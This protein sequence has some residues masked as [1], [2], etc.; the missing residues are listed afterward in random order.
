MKNTPLNVIV[1]TSDEMRADCLGFMGNPDV[2]TPCLYAFARKGVVFENHFTVHGKCVPSRVAMMTGRYCHTDGFRTITQHLPKGDPNLMTF[3]RRRGYETAVFGHNHVWDD[4][5]CGEEKEKVRSG[6]AADYHSFVKPFHDMAFTAYAVP[7]SSKPVECMIPGD[8]TPHSGRI[9]GAIKGFNDYNRARQAVHY[10]KNVRDRSKPFYLHVNMG[11]PHPAYRVEEPFFSMYDRAKIKTW[12]H[13]VP[14]NAPL[15]FRVMRE[16]RTG[17]NIS[18]RELREVQAVY[19]GMISRGDR[20]LGIV[21]ECIERDGLLE[22]SI[23]LFTTDHGDFAGQYGLIE[24]WDT[25]MADCIMRSPMILH[26]PGL[27]SGVRVLGLTEHVDI[28]STVLDLL[29]LAPDWGVHGE[30]LLPFIRG[31]RRKDAVF[32]DGGHEDEMHG[33]FSFDAKKMGDVEKELNGKQRTY[34]DSPDTMARTKMA[35]TERWKLVI[36]LRGGNELYD[37]KA[38]P[39]ELNNLWGEHLKRPELQSVVM[40]LQQRMIEWCLRT[41]TDRPRQELVGA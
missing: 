14:A 17:V 36:R 21:L 3:L 28:P 16:V 5:F 13:T 38:D 33:R 32:G 19:Y 37:I 35:R 39:F 10:L 18:E 24:K 31:E 22:N 27:R 41:D 7:T 4:L 26:A 40:D 11:T 23:V 2:K 20:D 9:D 6:G 29:G 1:L 15:P 25:C 34:R 8:G 30:S 12:P